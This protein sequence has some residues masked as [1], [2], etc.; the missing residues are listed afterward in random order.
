MQGYVSQISNENRSDP[1]TLSGPTYEFRGYKIRI[2]WVNFDPNSFGYSYD[3]CLIW[4]T[5]AQGT[6]YTNRGRV[7]DPLYTSFDY[8]LINDDGYKRTLHDGHSNHVKV[9]V[10]FE[11]KENTLICRVETDKVNHV[12]TFC[13]A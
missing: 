8:F 13:V 10:E 2:A 3:G 5:D 4:I 1:L 7:D 9:L 11:T 12:L 6:T